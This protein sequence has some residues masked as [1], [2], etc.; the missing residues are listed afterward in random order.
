[1]SSEERVEGSPNC[2]HG[3][4]I[5]ASRSTHL[6][7]RR[8]GLV[9]CVRKNYETLGTLLVNSREAEAN[10][11]ALLDRIRS[12]MARLATAVAVVETDPDFDPDRGDDI[13]T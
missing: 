9:A 6:F 3:L 1:M 13:L 10:A 11:R 2:E 5:R 7:A 4:Q 8:A 12:G